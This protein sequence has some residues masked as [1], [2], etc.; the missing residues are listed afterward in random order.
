MYDRGARKQHQALIDRDEWGEKSEASSNE[1]SFA[2]PARTSLELA[3][4]RVLFSTFRTLRWR[5]FLCRRP[6]SLSNIRSNS[7]IIFQCDRKLADMHRRFMLQAPSLNNLCP[8]NPSHYFFRNCAR[9]NY[10]IVAKSLGEEFYTRTA[11]GCK[12]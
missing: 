4:N 5:L 7:G 12:Q 8:L 3:D 2:P 11:F 10:F 6:E 9:Q 1:I